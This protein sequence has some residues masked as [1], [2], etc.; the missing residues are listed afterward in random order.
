[1]A[2]PT[3][4]R[5]A[6]AAP[7]TG[8]D[9]PRTIMVEPRALR[10][11][12]VVVMPVTAMEAAVSPVWRGVEP[13]PTLPTPLRKYV[14]LLNSRR[15]RVRSGGRVADWVVGEMRRRMREL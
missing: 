8:R 6:M 11:E 15:I 1:M 7:T 13:I 3:V 12:V 10:M 9:K 2:I 14:R 5:A 4:T